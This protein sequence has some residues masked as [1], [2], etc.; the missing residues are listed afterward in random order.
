MFTKRGF[1]I[2]WLGWGVGC[3]SEELLALE[4][5]RID[6]FFCGMLA[7]NGGVEVW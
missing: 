4:C 3:G 5:S 6:V 7:S 2:A 1:G